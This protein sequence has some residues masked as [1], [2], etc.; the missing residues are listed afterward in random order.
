MSADYGDLV[1]PEFDTFTVVLLVRGANPP[2]LTD[3]ELDDLQRAHL[4]HLRELRRIGVIL[5]NGP[6]FADDSDRVRG[7]SIYS[8]S[9]DAA[10]RHAEADPMVRA[11]RLAV[12]VREWNVAAG[13]IAFPEGAWPSGG[14][15]GSVAEPRQEAAAPG[16]AEPPG[17]ERS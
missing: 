4:A 1:P 5:V 10:R 9:P 6:I 8:V 3:Q 16:V 15:S 7:L 13:S 17:A 12:E 2:S 14:D 11:G